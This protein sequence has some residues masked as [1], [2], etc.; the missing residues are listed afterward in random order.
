MSVE[1]LK[2]ITDDVKEFDN[3]DDFIKLINSQFA[4]DKEYV[5]EDLTD[6]SFTKKDRKVVQLREYAAKALDAMMTEMRAF[7]YTDVFVTS[8]YHSY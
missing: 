7:G 3:K 8:A 6:I 5:P 2:R 1:V 4:L